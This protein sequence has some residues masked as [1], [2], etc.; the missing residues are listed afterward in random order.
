MCVRASGDA[1]VAADA[2]RE[3]VLAAMLSL[4]HLRQ[5]D[6]FGSWLVGIG[7]NMCRRL[8]RENGRRAWSRE[9][10]LGGLWA[11]QIAGLEP[12]PADMAEAVLLA[13][14][15][16]RAIASLPMGQRRA[17]VLY[18]LAGLT[19]AEV[20]EHLGTP[21]SAVKTRLHKAR[22]TLRLQLHDLWKD[23][24]AMPHKETDTT[25]PVRITDVRRVTD[26]EGGPDKHIVLLESDDDTVTVPIWIGSNEGT[27]LAVSLEGIDLPRPTTYQLTATLLETV[28][29]GLREVRISRLN[30]GVFYAQVVLRD[31]IAV[32]ARPSDALNLALILRTPISVERAVVATVVGPDAEVPSDAASARE[33]AGDAMRRM[34]ASRPA[35]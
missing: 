34:E 5:S 6:R 27:A 31:G 9:D 21:V 35:K 10:A 8:M 13:A 22:A 17:V 12:D 26:A 7:L 28:G 3:A 32:D 4:T 24:L 11:G 30:E 18:Y 19:Q 25:I 33:I 1:T 15:V 14:G 2:A 20:A 29:S 16:Q 23:E